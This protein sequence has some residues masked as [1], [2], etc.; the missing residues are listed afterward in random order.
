MTLAKIKLIT[1]KKNI[2]IHR[3]KNLKKKT[4]KKEK[5]QRERSQRISTR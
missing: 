5:G 3:G 1:R 4:E 2:Q